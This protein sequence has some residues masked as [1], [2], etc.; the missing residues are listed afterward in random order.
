[1]ATPEKNLPPL[2]F[3][4]QG[5]HFPKYAIASLAIAQ[6]TT[7][8]PLIVLADVAR[9]RGVKSSVRWEIIGEFYDSTEFKTFKAKSSLNP[10]FRDGFW[11]H[12]AERF[13][14]LEQFMTRH[15]FERL[16]HGELDC[17]FFSL[18]TVGREI[19]AAGLEGLFITRETIDRAVGSLVYVNT[20][21]SLR[22]ACLLLLE[23]VSLGNEMDILGSLPLGK[24]TPFYA[25]PSAEYLF[26]EA[27]SA[28]KWPVAPESPR[29]IVDGA[30]LGR[31][32]FGVDPRNTRDGGTRNLVQNPK[33][34]LP[35]EPPVSNLRFKASST[36]RW[37]IFVSGT[38]GVWFPLY[39]IHVHSKIHSKLTPRYARLIIRK[40]SKGQHH[41]ILR[42]P[43]RHYL[44]LAGR[45][46]RHLLRLARDPSE[47]RELAGNLFS[48]SWRKGLKGRVTGK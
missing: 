32:L 5:A 28:G 1:V 13:F 22:S 36:K 12:A 10:E 29:F 21:A 2:V 34:T 43:P 41:T 30:V 33:N 35:F 42:A 3:V 27:G 40:A 39:V 16:F 24:K 11:F 37:Q 7:P 20:R 19:E 15:A 9:P 26:R 14:V 23:N 48:P 8:N 31:W 18:D 46:I 38:S 45:I 17:L 25:F 4:Y 47:A 44:R 6:E